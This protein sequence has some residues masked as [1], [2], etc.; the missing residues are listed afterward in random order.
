[1][2]NTLLQLGDGLF[3]LAGQAAVI[4]GTVLLLLMIVALATYA[5]KHVRGDGIEWPDDESEEDAD[6][7]SRS[8]DDEWK[9]S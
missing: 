7:V 8:N 6:A 3:E 5:Y 1:M 4:A 9:Y 2:G